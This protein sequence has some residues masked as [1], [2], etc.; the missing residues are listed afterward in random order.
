L[1]LSFV[2]VQWIFDLVASTSPLLPRLVAWRVRAMGMTANSLTTPLLA[3]LLLAVLALASEQRVVLR[4]LAVVTALAAL[5]LAAGSGILALDA[6][7]LG[8]SVPAAQKT[9]YAL[10]AVFA[11]FKL[12][13][14][15]LSLVTLAWVEFKAARRLGKEAAAATRS[16]FLV[17]TP[18]DPLAATVGAGE[19]VGIEPPLG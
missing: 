18:T 14:G 16:T 4:V 12:G 17:R 13:F 15:I 5:A 7:Q 11:L 2:A 19:S 6:V 1:I 10:S 3:L 9:Q 8:R